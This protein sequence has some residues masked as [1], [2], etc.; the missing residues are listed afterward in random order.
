MARGTQEEEDLKAGR[1]A[2]D[3]SG[4]VCGALYFLWGDASSAL[5]LRAP[6]SR[7]WELTRCAYRAAG[8]RCARAGVSVPPVLA[9][10]PPLWFLLECFV[11]RQERKEREEN[12]TEERG[13]LPGQGI[14]VSLYDVQFEFI[15]TLPFSTRIVVLRAILNVVGSQIPADFDRHI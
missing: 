13:Y 10:H 12:K 7:G 6:G 4:G 15:P 9:M 11:F 8:A 14:H 5:R 2:G 3:S 1:M